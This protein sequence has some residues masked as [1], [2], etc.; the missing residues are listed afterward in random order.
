MLHVWVAAARFVMLFI[1]AD[2]SDPLITVVAQDE[3]RTPFRFGRQQSTLLNDTFGAIE[4]ILR[5]GC[6]LRRGGKSRCRKNK[7]QAGQ[8]YNFHGSLSISSVE[9][10]KKS[11]A[12]DE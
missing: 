8:S 9:R 7:D 1:G 5:R 10:S 12:G 4:R 3:R 6:I 2:F 11:K